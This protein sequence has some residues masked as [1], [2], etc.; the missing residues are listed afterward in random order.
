MEFEQIQKKEL[1]KDLSDQI[2]LIW[3][4]VLNNVDGITHRWK[5]DYLDYLEELRFRDISALTIKELKQPIQTL[6]E[7]E[8]IKDEEYRREQEN[9]VK[10]VLVNTKESC[11]KQKSEFTADVETP[12]KLLDAI[13]AAPDTNNAEPVY[14]EIEQS[15][16]IESEPILIS[17]ALGDTDSVTEIEPVVEVKEEIYRPLTME[18]KAEQIAEEIRALHMSYD[19][20]SAK[21]KAGIYRFTVTDTDYDL[22]LHSMVL[23][24]LGVSRRYSSE[25]FDEYNEIID[26][27]NKKDI[28]YQQKFIGRDRSR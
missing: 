26:A 22:K 21:K 3:T 8:Q 9:N 7:Y 13:S 5:Y 2:Q 19:D 10:S 18:E 15:E 6:E 25:T 11:T 24:E 20:I 1:Q 4:D 14:D 16:K 12:V 23:K 17:D 27:M 28:S